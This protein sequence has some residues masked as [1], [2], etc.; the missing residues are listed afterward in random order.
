[1]L[2]GE[3]MIVEQPAKESANTMA[4]NLNNGF[5]TAVLLGR[6]SRCCAELLFMY[7]SR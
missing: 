3:G 6:L 7:P 4:L 5:T 1:M 2:I